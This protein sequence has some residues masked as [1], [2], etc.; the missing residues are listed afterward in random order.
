MPTKRTRIK[1]YDESENYVTTKTF[2]SKRERE[3]FEFGM[4]IAN[5]Y[6]HVY[7]VAVKLKKRGRRHA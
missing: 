6:G 5:S 1:I 2:Y 3:A 7:I 4:N